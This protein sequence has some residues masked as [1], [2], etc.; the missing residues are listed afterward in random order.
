M[1]PKTPE[2]STAV[3]VLTSD[4]QKFSPFAPLE[5]GG[6]QRPVGGDESVTLLPHHMQR[7]ANPASAQR[8]APNGGGPLDYNTYYTPADYYSSLAKEHSL[9]S[10]D[11]S[12]LSSP[13]SDS[14]AQP[15]A[16]GVGGSTTAAPVSLFQF[17]IGK[18]LEDE[19]GVQVGPGNHGPDCEL[20]VFYEGLA[21]DV[22]PTSSL[23]LH[24][25]DRTDTE[26]AVGDQRQVKRSVL[27]GSP[28]LCS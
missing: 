6:D 4:F 5:E 22:G 24:P 2:G 11:S 3:T 23:Q 1:A 25:A 9:E 26:R 21:G 27:M 20:P 16:S 12:T 18:I 13:P 7:G 28:N 19:G 10:Q 15:M 14:L 17:S 8:A